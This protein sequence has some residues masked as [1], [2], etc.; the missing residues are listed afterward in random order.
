MNK[1]KLK[2]SRLLPTICVVV[3]ALFFMLP[4]YIAFSNAFKN[5]DAIMSSPLSLP[6]PA[7]LDNIKYVLTNPN[8]DVWKMYGNSI[9]ITAFGATGCIL[10]SS[11]AAYYIT[12]SKRKKLTGVLYLFFLMG[13][14]VPYVIVYVP[15]TSM[16][17]ILNIKANLFI[18]ILVFISGSISFSVFMYCGFIRSIPVELEEA[19]AIDGASPVTIFFKVVFP[20]LKPCTTTV[21][22]F[23]G[24]SMWNDFMTPLL[25]GQIQ[26]ITVGIYTA[27]GP[28]SADWGTVFAFVLFG[29][30]PILIAYLCAQKQFISGLTSGAI[31]G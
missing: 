25:I 2:I 10:I 14:M 12:R 20:L 21:A 9:A 3:L 30:V 8:V 29:S 15:L 7:T 4:I 17:N 1:Q 28:Y 6:W 27:I 31:K 18:L 19:A 11:L 13:L 23:I 5:S 22:I 16:L 24:L 26:T